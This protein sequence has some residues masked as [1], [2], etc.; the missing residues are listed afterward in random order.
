[1]FGSDAEAVTELL[2]RIGI[3]PPEASLN[4]GTLVLPFVYGIGTALPVL[5]VAFLLAYSAQS[6]GKTYNMLSK[7]D[8]WARQVTG[9]V[10]ILAGV[11]F[12]LK[13]AFEVI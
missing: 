13:Y 6:V 4:G 7:V 5:V 1:M 10:F 8:W 12:S 3:S 11:Y 9:W 2:A